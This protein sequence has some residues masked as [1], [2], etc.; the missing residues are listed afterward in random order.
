MMTLTLGDFAFDRGELPESIAFGCSQKLQVHTLVG[1]ARVIDAL[2]SVPLR[3]EWSGWFS[4]PQALARARYLKQLAEDG[5]PLPL[6]FGEFAYIVLIASFFAEFRAGPHL[7]YAI[8]LEVVRD[9]GSAEPG[10]GLPG[11]VQAVTQ[12]LVSAAANAAAIGDGGLIAAVSA[13]GAAATAGS[14]GEFTPAATRM[15]MPA[16]AAAHAQGVR[17]QSAAT[18]QLAAVGPLSAPDAAGNGLG[19]DPLSRFGEGLVAAADAARRSWRLNATTQALGRVTSNLAAATGRA[20]AGGA[21]VT[22][23]STDLYHLAAAAYG[24]ARGWTRIAQANRLTDPAISGITQVVI[25][26]ADAASATGVLHA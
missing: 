17:L 18:A 26:R 19:P 22:A 12:D 7:P 23:G 9:L 2:G 25:P 10:A 3:P 6:R 21:V 1:G 15:L 20:G 5:Q 8:A 16:I 4:G 11:L 14:N 24:D 13:I